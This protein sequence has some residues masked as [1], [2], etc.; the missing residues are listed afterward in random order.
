M[1]IL[2]PIS[3]DE[4]APNKIMQSHIMEN[5]LMT[6]VNLNSNGEYGVIGDRP[7]R[8]GRHQGIKEANLKEKE[9]VTLYNTEQDGILENV[10]SGYE[11]IKPSR[12]Y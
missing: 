2:K 5:N 12:L 10:E 11:E 3:E 7:R 1:T 6:N 9:L 4:A 8:Y